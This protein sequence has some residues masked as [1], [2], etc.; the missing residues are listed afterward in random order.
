[1]KII[2]GTTGKYHITSQQIADTNMALFGEEE[3]VL[4]IGS[5]FELT[6]INTNTITI[7]DGMLMLQGRRGGTDFGK[8]DT[9]LIANGAQG[10]PRNDL[11]VARYTCDKDGIED[12]TPD[13]VQGSNSG[14]DPQ[15]TTGTIRNGATLHEMPL[16]RVRLNG[17]NIDGI[18]T[19]FTEYGAGGGK[20]RIGDICITT[21]PYPPKYG[22]WISWGEGRIPI[23]V[24]SNDLDFSTSEKTGGAKTVTLTTAQLPSHTHESVAHAHS[25]AAFN[26]GNQSA[27]HTH[28]I[29][30]NLQSAGG[31]ARNMLAGGNLYPMSDGVTSTTSANSA[32]HTHSVPA[33]NTASTT[34]AATGASGSG[35]A[36]S[37]MNPY[38]TCYY[39]KRIA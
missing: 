12:I 35:D 15:L 2:D 21:L 29:S 3:Y 22:T 23:G 27:N 10:V 1:M 20:Y 26:T 16:Y 37:I 8:R 25:V 14:D 6:V 18:D 13:I 24:N 32:N 31:N 38:I 33:H 19:L 5:K 39:F 34:P 4:D 30:S 36:H 17:I 28:T 9:L 11:I 7:G